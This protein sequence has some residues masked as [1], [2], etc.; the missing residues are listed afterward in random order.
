MQAPPEVL[1]KESMENLA[2][3]VHLTECTLATVEYMG[4]LKSRNKHE[5]ERHIQIAQE[6]ISHI[7]T[8]APHAPSPKYE[9]YQTALRRRLISYTRVDSVINTYKGRVKDWIMG[10]KEQ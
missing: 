5:Y 4:D 9:M 6:G 2:T 7:R 3:V 1:M 8:H 10:N